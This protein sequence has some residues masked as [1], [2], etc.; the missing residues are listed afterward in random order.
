[1]ASCSGICANDATPTAADRGRSL[2]KNDSSDSAYRATMVGSPLSHVDVETSE[3]IE[4]LTEQIAALEGSLGSE[5]RRGLAENRLHTETRVASL[6]DE[7]RDEILASRRHAQVFFE[8]TRDDI[9]MIAEA[10]AI[11]SAKFDTRS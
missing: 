5:F 4:R 1:M 6:R 7:L 3:A 11:M 9:R 8:S 2:H 10:V